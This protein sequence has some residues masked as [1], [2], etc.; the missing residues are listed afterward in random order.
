MQNEP[1]G[2]R[3]IPFGT[4]N[5]SDLDGRAKHMAVKI[6]N[7]WNSTMA[8]RLFGS[9]HELTLLVSWEGI[10][11]PIKDGHPC[12]FLTLRAMSLVDAYISR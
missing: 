8:S 6:Y 1:D 3:R 9:Q 4:D 7:A 11:A 10:P 12:E 2:D 5:T